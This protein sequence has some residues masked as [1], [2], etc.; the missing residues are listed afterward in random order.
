M[1]KPTA[2]KQSHKDSKASSPSSSS[3][4][5]V[6]RSLAAKRGAGT[7]HALSELPL[8]SSIRREAI[9][10]RRFLENKS[11]AAAGVAGASVDLAA[12]KE[13]AILGSLH[14]QLRALRPGVYADQG[15]EGTMD[16]DYQ[17]SEEDFALLVERISND[18]RNYNPPFDFTYE[19]G[20]VVDYHDDT[21]Y[22]VAAGVYAR[23]RP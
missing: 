14:F 8:G 22:G 1:P 13:N 20:F 10:L 3:L 23:T 12:A 19:I 15:L 21:G 4:I 6:V 11:L 5:K 18:L 17:M 2:K 16:D 7:A 9:Y